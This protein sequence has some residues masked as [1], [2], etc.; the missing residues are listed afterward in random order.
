MNVSGHRISTTEVESAFVD[1]PNV[2]EA[3][4]VSK[5][6]DIT[7]EAVAAFITLKGGGIGSPAEADELRKHVALKIG[8]FAK[9]K[10]IT[11]TPDLPKTRSG[12]IM[13]RLLKQIAS[14]QTVTGDT[15]TLEDFSILA[16]LQ[17]TEE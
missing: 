13:R 11:F 4:V 10:Y 14:G 1:H 7:G 17:K 3:A 9:P 5:K 8:A 16:R 12:K 15:T 6:D 2:A